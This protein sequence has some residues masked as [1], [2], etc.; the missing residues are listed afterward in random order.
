MALG[1]YD[2]GTNQR[3]GI[4]SRNQR[5]AAV[6]GIT[7][8]AAL[9]ICPMSTPSGWAT[10]ESSHGGYKTCPIAQTVKATATAS[11]GSLYVE[12]VPNSNSGSQPYF[13]SLSVV[14]GVHTTFPVSWHA[15]G[16]TMQS[17]VATCV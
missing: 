7:A 8:A 10:S 1:S 6:I 17:A 14:S 15:D 16:P 11:S 13:W 2:A 12:A 4:M 3:K 5:R 9:A